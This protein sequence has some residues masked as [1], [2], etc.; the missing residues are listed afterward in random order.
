MGGG[1]LT[2]ED[3]AEMTGFKVESLRTMH[4]RAQRN[5]AAG[6][7]TPLDMPPP[8]QVFGRTPTWKPATI[9]AW[10]ALRPD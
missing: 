5:R 7:S 10:M 1:Y 3:V 2:Y 6:K 8:D 4:W 9:R